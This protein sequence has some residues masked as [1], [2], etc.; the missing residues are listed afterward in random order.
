[1]A[2][3][4]KRGHS[5]QISVNLGADIYG[6]RIRKTTTFKPP[7]GTTEKKAYKLAQQFAF[8]YEAKIK[9]MC[10][11]KE[12]M[13]FSEL[14]DWFFENYAPE[15]LKGSS[16]YHY[17]STVNKHLLPQLGNM[18]LKEFTPAKITAHFKAL[19]KNGLGA[20]TCAKVYAILHSIFDRAVG[21]GFIKETPCTKAVILPK[22]PKNNRRSLSEQE[23]YKLLKLTEESTE[24]NR[25]VRIL[26]FTGMR[27]GE[28]LALSWEDIDFEHKQI[29][30]SKTLARIKGGQILQPPKSENSNR[31]I[32]LWDDLDLLFKAQKQ[33]DDEKNKEL[34]MF[35]K[36]PEMVF[37]SILG[38][39]ANRKYL[40]NQF[41]CI[42]N[43]NF[44]DC[45][46]HTLRHTFATVLISGGADV[47]TASKMLGHANIQTT[48]D[49]YADVFESA[50][51]RFYKS[52]ISSMKSFSNS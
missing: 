48:A 52:A 30:I 37:T 40:G 35:C 14:C 12:N 6:K 33:Y 17:K 45:T 31:L 1:M 43:D 5:F 46:F 15:N 9:G 10:D 39:Y 20:S 44:P 51:A 22:V 26:L 11:L 7:K 41:K 47:K 13:R 38:N 34:G 21:N 23:V 4:T 16:A 28:C 50:Q 29:H 19:H 32:P 24:I 2:S 8:E 42:T 3:I 18:K 25:L 49:I 27:I 36:H